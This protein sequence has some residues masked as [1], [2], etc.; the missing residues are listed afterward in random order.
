M[1]ARW[2]LLALGALS[3]AAGCLGYVDGSAS[4]GTDAATPPDGAS[5]GVLGHAEP[6][7]PVLGFMVFQGVPEE[8]VAPHVPGDMDPVPC[9]FERPEGTVDA[10]L[11]VTE[12]RFEDLPGEAGEANPRH[13]SLV[14]CAERPEG[15]ERQESNEPP[16]VELLAWVDGP[17]Y[18]QALADLGYPAPA[19]EVDIEEAP[20]GFAFAIEADDGTPVVEGRLSEG[21]VGVPGEPAFSC[22]PQPFDGRAITEGEGGRIGAMDWNKTETPCPGTAQVSWPE[23]SPLADVLGPAHPPDMVLNVHVQEAEYTWR[24]L[25]AP[26]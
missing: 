22:E 18:R 17:P 25:Q 24:T 1:R 7:V 23:Q 16:W 6:E 13:A 4:E 12:E 20:T 8:R 3:L 21:G 2:L 11:V 14:G 9:F 26:G 15:M 5:V 10:V 19:A